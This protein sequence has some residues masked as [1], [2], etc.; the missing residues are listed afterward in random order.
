VPESERVSFGWAGLLQS[1]QVI[2]CCM[3]AEFYGPV[4]MQMDQG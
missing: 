4:C 1:F 2:G 3:H